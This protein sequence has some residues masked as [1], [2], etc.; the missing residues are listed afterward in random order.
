MPEWYQNTWHSCIHCY[1]QHALRDRFCITL[2]V[3]HKSCRKCMYKLLIHQCFRDEFH[4][5]ELIFNVLL[6]EEE[7]IAHVTTYSRA[8]RHFE[9]AR[10][11]IILTSSLSSGSGR[12]SVDDPCAMLRLDEISINTLMLD[13]PRPILDPILFVSA[14]VLSWPFMELAGFLCE[15]RE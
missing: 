9:S 8:R 1:R 7:I 4:I 13:I 6:T 10:L 11:V 12:R 15:L 5:Q 3:C 2:V 14:Q